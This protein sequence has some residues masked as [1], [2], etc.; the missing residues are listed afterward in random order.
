M[1]D[2]D[3]TVLSSE[4]PV[5]LEFWASWCA[6]CVMSL[7]EVKYLYGKYHDKGLEIIGVNLDTDR[8]QLDV[9]RT[10][11]AIQGKSVAVSIVL[12]A[13]GSMAGAK[14]ERVNLKT[15]S[16]ISGGVYPAWHPDGRSLAVALGS[17]IRRWRCATCSGR[18]CRGDF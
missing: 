6:P 11:S 10:R 17:T 8:R 2:F 15:K 16:T 5:L 7:P 4:K 9:F 3:S 14:L 12:D 1:R 18:C 13:S